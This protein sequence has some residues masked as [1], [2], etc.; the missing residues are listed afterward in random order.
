MSTASSHLHPPPDVTNGWRRAF[1]A[2]ALQPR[3]R[4]DGFG[5]ITVRRRAERLEP[6]DP[7]ARPSEVVVRSLGV[8][9]LHR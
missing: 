1:R 7:L 4:H 8:H 9:D 5:G 6:G 3:T 2:R